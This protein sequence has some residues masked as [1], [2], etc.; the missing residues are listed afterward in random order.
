MTTR[1]MF[2]S[3]SKVAGVGQESIA[4]LRKKSVGGASMLRMDKL[5]SNESK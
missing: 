2:Y 1:N 3:F 4:K 5:G